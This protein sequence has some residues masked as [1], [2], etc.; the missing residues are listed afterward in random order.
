MKAFLLVSL[1]SV[2]VV[3]NAALK[4]EN[5]VLP[6]SPVGVH[7]F[8]KLKI[9]D[10]SELGLKLFDTN[11]G[12]PFS[13]KIMVLNTLY[14]SKNFKKWVL[15]QSNMLVTDKNSGEITSLPNG[16]TF[17]SVSG[18]LN[19]FVLTHGLSQGELAKLQKTLLK[20]T[21]D[22]NVT[23]SYR[24]EKASRLLNIADLLLVNQ[25]AVAAPKCLSSNDIQQKLQAKDESDFTVLKGLKAC[26]NGGGLG[27][28][29]ATVGPITMMYDVLTKGSE[30]ILCGAASVVGAGWQ[31]CS[32][33]AQA[34]ENTIDSTMNTLGNIR[35][36]TGEMIEG[37][38]AL[39]GDVQLLVACEVIG[40]A[41][42]GAAV[43]FATFGAG[44]PGAITSVAQAL[45]RVASMPGVGKSSTALKSMA[46]ALEKKAADKT[47]ALARTKAGV[48]DVNKS[49]EQVKKLQKEYDDNAEKRNSAMVKLANNVKAQELTPTRVGAA[50]KL[51]TLQG[52]LLRGSD[53][54]NRQVV[55]GLMQYAKL[56]DQ[57]RIWAK[58]VLASRP[59]QG[60]VT[61]ADGSSMM[62]LAKSIQQRELDLNPELKVMSQKEAAQ[63]RD[64]QKELQAEVKRMQ[65]AVA[66]SEEQLNSEL[67]RYVDL[68]EK[69]ANISESDRDLYRA[70]V[71]GYA[72]AVLC[73]SLKGSSESASG[74]VQGASGTR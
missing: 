66:V 49:L 3:S 10:D 59:Q 19:F 28:K 38:S 16:N 44:A 74:T 40:T 11:I 73:S 35:Q 5:L 54:T 18:D 61:Y 56:T 27:V 68:V 14:T 45:N 64:A 22:T 4:K 31:R 25:A 30:Q 50:N 70:Q 29:N 1:L 6:V 60:L 67:N 23:T 13:E 7:D 36:V 2:S 47:A 69:K 53:V 17:F 55:A 71:T 46:N 12:L 24:L 15:I 62:R 63:V 34:M 32:E 26:G 72:T 43:S 37:Y 21:S 41:G 8:E 39:P 51:M 52:A 58:S 33:Y 57:E 9:T 42:A 48:S 20:N 65:K